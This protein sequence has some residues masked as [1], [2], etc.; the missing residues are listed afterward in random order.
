VKCGTPLV[1]T[2]EENV[3]CEDPLAPRRGR[4]RADLLTVRCNT[5]DVSAYSELTS[6]APS[7]VPPPA[8]LLEKRRKELINSFN[9]VGAY[10]S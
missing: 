1:F 7:Y 6:F 3:E 10:N 2:Y 8:R 5:C 4:Y 9:R